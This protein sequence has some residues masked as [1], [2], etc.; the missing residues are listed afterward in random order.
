[1]AAPDRAALSRRDPEERAQEVGGRDRRGARLAGRA[2]RDRSQAVSRPGW[3]RDVRADPLRRTPRERA[4]DARAF[5][6]PDRGRAHTPGPAPWAGAPPAGCAPL[7]APARASARTHP[8][9]GGPLRDRLR[10]RLD[11]ARWRAAGLER[12]PGVGRLGPLE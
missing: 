4:G 1:M 10:P 2:R 11:A 9:G 8:A 12:P 5:H 7:G 6:A 3:R